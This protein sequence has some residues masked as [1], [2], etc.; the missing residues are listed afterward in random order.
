VQLR[1]WA[2]KSEVELLQRAQHGESSARDTRIDGPIGFIRQ[3]QF[4]ES[5]EGRGE[6]GLTFGSAIGFGLECGRHAV[7]AQFG[8]LRFQHAAFGLG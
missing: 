4:D 8:Q 3:L 2:E 1:G 7:E 6:A 5:A